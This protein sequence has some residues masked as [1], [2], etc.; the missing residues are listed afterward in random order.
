M[1]RVGLWAVLV[2]GAALIVAPLSTGMFSKAT[3]G[4]R[5]MKA[6]EPV[7]SDA[8]VTTTEKDFRVVSGMATSM[9][10]AMSPDRV[11]R[12]DRYLQNMDPTIAESQAFI[13]GVA[14]QLGT[15]PVTL[16]DTLGTD[17]PH[18]ALMLAVM[19]Q[20]R[21]DMA[22][23]VGLMKENA[24]GFTAMP[25]TMSRFAGLI[26]TMRGQVTNFRKANAL[27]PMGLL[28]WFLLVPGVLLALIAGGL[29]VLEYR[30]AQPF[31]EVPEGRTLRAA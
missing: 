11:A 24:A 13:Q 31:V 21:L 22:G 10:P 26:Q 16:S 20:M 1:K 25:V 8:S 3:A 23:M 9:A 28:P 6:F 27:P 14:T 5:M 15:D 4:Q 17:Y 2:I 18:L 19:P 12:F 29:L 30:R 7:M